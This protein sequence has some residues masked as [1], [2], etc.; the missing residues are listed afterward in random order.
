MFVSVKLEAIQ[1][2]YSQKLRINSGAEFHTVFKSN[3][4]FQP[5][6]GLAISSFLNVKSHKTAPGRLAIR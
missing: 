3:E 5:I 1:N 4:R 2:L 6:G